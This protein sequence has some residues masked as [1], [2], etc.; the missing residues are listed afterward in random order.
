MKSHDLSIFR[1]LHH[2]KSMFQYPFAHP[3]PPFSPTGVGIEHHPKKKGIS[4][5]TD[6]CF[7]DVKQIPTSWDINPNPCPTA[8]SKMAVYFSGARWQDTRR[9]AGSPH[10]R[11]SGRHFAVASPDE[12][13]VREE[14][15]GPFFFHHLSVKHLHMYL[16]TY[17]ISI[18]VCFVLQMFI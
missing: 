16:Y 17:I 7:G 8:R 18:R 10:A 2:V 6:N 13:S 14:R 1:W 11:R 9:H 15:S 4:S 12:G 3:F 5:P